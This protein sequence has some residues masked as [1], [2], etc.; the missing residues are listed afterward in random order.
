[1]ME[2][3]TFAVIRVEAPVQA[4]SSGIVPP[5]C[6]ALCAFATLFIESQ[7]ILTGLAYSKPKN[8]RSKRALDAREPKEVED[9]RTVI[10]VKGTHT[11]EVLNGVF[12][13]LM[14]LKRPHA[15]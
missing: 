5:S 2:T 12:K 10:F 14:A 1:M 3:F 8:A 6:Y 11:G 15:Y 7:R 4:T 9:P 13:D